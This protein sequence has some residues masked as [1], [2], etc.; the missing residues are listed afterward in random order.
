MWT[1]DEISGGPGNDPALRQRWAD[2]LA[3]VEHDAPALVIDT[4]P[5]GIGGF[6]NF[7]IRDTPLE[8]YLRRHYEKVARIRGMVVWRR[9]PVAAGAKSS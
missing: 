1:R 6:A 4:A 8:A 5:R 2:Y 7:P 3:D 9:L